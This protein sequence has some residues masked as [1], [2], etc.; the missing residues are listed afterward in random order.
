MKDMEANRTATGAARALQI[1]IV[2]IP[3]SGGDEETGAAL[4]EACEQ[5]GFVFV[6][7][8]GLGFSTD[9]LDCTFELV[10]AWDAF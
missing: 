3:R 7:G 4:V 10:R 8:E 1:P 2:D 9:S 6:R 5:Y